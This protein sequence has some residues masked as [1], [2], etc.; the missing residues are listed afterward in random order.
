MFDILANDYLA[1]VCD[2]E[3][4]MSR[5][6]DDYLTNDVQYRLALTLN[7]KILLVLLPNLLST[8]VPNF[9]MFRKTNFEVHVTENPPLKKIS[10]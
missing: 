2:G 9:K 3:Y 5:S 4:D 1:K 6:I 7:Q 8:N 10:V